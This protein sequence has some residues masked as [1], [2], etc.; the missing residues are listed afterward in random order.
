MAEAGPTATTVV[1]VTKQKI[2]TRG[3]TLPGRGS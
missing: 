3:P 2:V 1:A